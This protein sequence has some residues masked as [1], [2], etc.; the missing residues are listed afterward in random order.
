MGNAFPRISADQ[1]VIQQ[2]LFLIGHIRD[3]QGKENVEPLDLGGQFRA[4]DTGAI[5]HFFHGLID[6]ADLQYVDTAFGGG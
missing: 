2:L 4:F 5:Q 1:G 3:Q 6:L